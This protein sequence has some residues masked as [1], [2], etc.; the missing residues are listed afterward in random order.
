MVD[1][2]ILVLLVLCMYWPAGVGDALEKGYMKSMF[3]GIS[4]DPEG[5]ELLEVRLLLG[6]DIICAVCV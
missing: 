6:H 5:A 3:F 1:H 2:C 4:E